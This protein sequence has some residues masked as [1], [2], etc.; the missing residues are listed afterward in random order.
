MDVEVGSL[1]LSECAL[2]GLLLKVDVSVETGDGLGLVGGLGEARSSSEWVGS[3]G[4]GHVEVLSVGICGPVSDWLLLRVV[5]LWD[6]R[7]EFLIWLLLTASPGA[8][9]D[10]KLLVTVIEAHI[11]P[12]LSLHDLSSHCI[13]LVIFWAVSGSSRCFPSPLLSL[14]VFVVFGLLHFLF[15]LLHDLLKENHNINNCQNMTK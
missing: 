6:L 2:V 5:A 7:V 8:L 12:I 13:L 3:D 10:N 15:N 9:L 4:G 1:G 14:E 11:D